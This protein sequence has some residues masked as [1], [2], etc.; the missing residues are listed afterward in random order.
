M[1]IKGYSAEEIIGKHFSVF[2]QDA[3][4]EKNHP[5]FELEQAVKYGSYEENGWRV[6]QDGS[7]FW[8][9]VVI[10]PVFEDEIMI[11][12]AKVTRDLTEQILQEQANTEFKSEIAKMKERESLVLTLTHDMKNP[13]IGALGVLTALEK[14]PEIAKGPENYLGLLKHGVHDVLSLTRDLIDVFRQ[15][16]G[17][18]FT[19]DPELELNELV[20]QAVQTQLA[21]A[22]MRQTKITVRLPAGSTPVYW[23]V[24]SMTRVFNNLIGNA[25]KFSPTHSTVDIHAFCTDQSIVVEVKD[26]GPGVQ[27]H[28][29]ALLFKPFSQGRLGTR[30]SG[31]SGLGL[32]S[33]KR[34]VEANNGRVEYVSKAPHGAL[35]RVEMPRATATAPTAA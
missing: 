14:N 26:E 18:S 35:F 25:I 16:L 3:D 31:G 30:C 9:C 6:R 7:L 17:Q 1:R 33:C 28:E 11:G 5:A 27:E 21:N 24:A 22:S 19:A 23:D 20:N 12:F 2:Y 15:E 4:N 34:L 13:L 10:T 8:A 32:F 29:I